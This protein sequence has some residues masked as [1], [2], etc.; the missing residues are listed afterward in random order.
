MNNQ[1]T[2]LLANEDVS[3]IINAKHQ[4]VFSVLGMHKHPTESG[5]VVRVFLPEALSVE[6]IDSKTNKLVAVLDCVDQA[7]LFESKLGR[8]RNAFSYRLRVS[9]KSDIVVIEDPYRYPSMI[10]LDDLYLFCEG[11]HE[12]TYQWMGAHERLVDNVKGVHFVLWA[13]DARRVSVVSDFNFWDGRRHVMR[14][15]PAAGVWEIFIPNI[16]AQASYK[17]EIADKN[18]YIQPLKADPYAFEMQNSPGTATKIVK[19]SDYQWQDGEWMS[20]RAT[21]S[22][23]YQGAVS[24]YEVQLGSWKRNG[25]HNSS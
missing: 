13:P 10:N 5:L 9:Y 2:S 4:D 11:T 17:Y 3:A 14:K 7:G 12:Q 25:A 16:V 6:V 23:H 24:I 20:E 1:A 8:R 15:H 21:S 19:S 22:N 18:G